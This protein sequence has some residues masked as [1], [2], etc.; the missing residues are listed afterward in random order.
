MVSPESTIVQKEVKLRKKVI[1]KRIVLRKVKKSPPPPKPKRGWI[2]WRER[3]LLGKVNPNKKKYYAFFLKTKNNVFITIT[4]I[5]GRVVV[6][7]SA[8]SCKITTKKK[9]KSW[10][11]LKA[12]AASASKIARIKNIRYIWKFFMTSTYMKNGKLIF[13]SF[14]QSGLS[15]LKAI[16]V[17]NRPH[18]LFMR[19]K[20][21]KRL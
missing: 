2:P 18:S 1:K 17:R 4:D 21:L 14:K 16:I 12:V 9:K 20:K 13:Q 15:I 11:T 3:F 7:Q 19:K 5:R 10:D 8:G 6:S